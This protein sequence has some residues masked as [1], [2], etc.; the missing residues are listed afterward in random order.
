M[1]DKCNRCGSHNLVTLS[2]I[3]EK[4]CVCSPRV[5]IKPN[6]PEQLAQNN[7]VKNK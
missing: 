2:S 5:P 3:N 7:R 6:E 4:R 1:A